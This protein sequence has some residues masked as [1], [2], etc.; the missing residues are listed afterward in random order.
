[1]RTILEQILTHPE[2]VDPSTL[3]EL[4]RYTKLF[5]INSGPYNHLTAR[6]TVLKCTPEAFE[7]AALRAKKN[8]AEMPAEGG[9]PFEEMLRRL[10]PSFFDPA[11]EPIVTNKSPGPGRG[12]PRRE[13]Q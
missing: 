6:K 4:Q 11:F 7:A 13:R 3:A 2:G 8:G 12:Y 9:V 10:R 1:M 5:W